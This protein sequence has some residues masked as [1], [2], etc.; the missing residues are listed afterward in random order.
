M[1]THHIEL[2]SDIES[3]DLVKEEFGVYSQSMWVSKRGNPLGKEAI[4]KCKPTTPNEVFGYSL[5]TGLG[6][7]MPRFK[8]VWLKNSFI[9]PDGKPRCENAIG[10]LIE[11]IVPSQEIYLLGA[12]EK[13]TKVSAMNLL[14]R[15]FLGEGEHLQILSC[16]SCMYF[17]DLEWIGP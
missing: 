11:K 5:A 13:D 12:V 1:G 7:P 16:D 15:L 9:H 4:F 3:L 14:M 6:M 10:L 2:I 17:Y 8:G